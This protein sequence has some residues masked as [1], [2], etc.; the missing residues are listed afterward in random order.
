MKDSVMTKIVI[1][2]ALCFL[3]VIGLGMISMLI[4]ER[5]YYHKSVMDDIKETHVR[6]QYVITPFLL[7]QNQN[8][9]QV[10]FA[11]SSNIDMLTSVSQ[12][13]YH[14]GIYHAISYNG[15]FTMTQN[16]NLKGF[17]KATKLLSNTSQAVKEVSNQNPTDG[18]QTA[19]KSNERLLETKSNTQ[20]KENKN[21]IKKLSL[22]IA[23]SDLRGVQPNEVMIGEKTYP[24]KF[25]NDGKLPFAYLEAD[26]SELLAQNLTQN[27]KLLTTE[28]KLS[29]AGIDSVHTI[30]LGDNFTASLK[31]N[32]NEPKFFGGALPVQ[33]NLTNQG[34]NAS[35]QA[36]FI[37]QKNENSLLSCLKDNE[38][39]PDFELEQNNYELLSTSFVQTTDTYIQ[40][41]RI[42]KYALLLVL[43]LFGTFFLFETIKGLRIH[44]VQYGL[45]ASALLVFYVLLLSLA[46]YVTFAL[47][48]LI[49]AASC[50]GLLGWYTSYVLSTKKRGVFFS[51]IVASLYSVFYVVLSSNSFNLI[52]GAVFCFVLIA[53]V[54][55]ITRNINWYELGAKDAHQNTQKQPKPIIGSAAKT[56]DNSPSNDVKE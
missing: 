17:D 43:V 3:F 4:S 28:L 10:L 22:V 48:Y 45:V 24:V 50:V 15:Q 44:P 39:C 13:E 41:E 27:P 38:K 54:M 14:R 1:I 47:A 31:S 18:T 6:E 53:L 29:V 26:L 46:E 8:N 32:W 52:L 55:Y 56:M 37:A 33:K 2:A 9:N 51:A 34:F 23:V 19:I 12:D 30:P 16:F 49:A 36:G 7:L 5:K 20:T 25:V 40:T 42:I 21:T 35:W 11:D